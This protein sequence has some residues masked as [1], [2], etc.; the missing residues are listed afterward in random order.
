[1]QCCAAGLR[2]AWTV[3]PQIL[4][5]KGIVHHAKYLELLRIL[6]IHGVHNKATLATAWLKDPTFMKRELLACIKP[7][8]QA[9]V[10]QLL[11]SVLEVAC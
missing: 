6:S 8:R 7:G 10:L 9:A 11:D 3:S 1:M 4:T 2:D 5:K